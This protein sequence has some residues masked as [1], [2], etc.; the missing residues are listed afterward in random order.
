MSLSITVIED[1]NQKGFTAFSETLS[2]CVAEGETKDIAVDNL[3]EQMKTLL[4]LFRN[5]HKVEIVTLSDNLEK[6]NFIGY[7]LD[8]K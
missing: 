2:E 5:N 3:I 4:D 7:K 6:Q 8:W 1:I